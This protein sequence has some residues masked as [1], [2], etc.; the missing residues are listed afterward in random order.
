M[1][2]LARAVRANAGVSAAYRDAL[3]RL[4]RRMARSMLRHARA[5][6]KEADP[7]H[8]MAH[9]AGPVFTLRR[10]LSLYGRQW[11]SRLNKL[12]L[13]LATR[14]ADKSFQATETSMKASFRDA[15]LT[16]KFKPTVGSKEAY[17]AVIAENVA[18]IK[19]VPQQYL[20]D[21]EQSVWQ[22]V[23]KGSTLSELT[24][25]I[26][27]KYGVAYRRAAFIAADQNAKAKAVIENTRRREMGIVEAVWLHSTAGKVPRPTHVAMNGKRYKLSDGMYDSH[28]K[29][30]I[31]P[32]Q[33]PRCRCVSKAI[34]PGFD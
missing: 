22:A 16:V 27:S 15:G 11:Q 10:S 19:S 29:E 7:S 9:D 4:V 32:G 28:V 18:L 13:T 31:W 33:L 25:D 1:P 23:M 20:K 21:L 3:Q 14:F 24:A 12:S 6:W 34:I 8:G 26:Q 17:R 2:R 5:A 30:Q